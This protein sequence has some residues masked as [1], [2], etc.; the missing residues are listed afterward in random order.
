[1]KKIFALLVLFAL[2]SSIGYTQNA[3]GDKSPA[4][5]KEEIKNEMKRNRR[6]SRINGV[7][8]PKDIDDAIVQLKKL[9]SDKSLTKFINADEKIVAKKLHFGIGRWMIVNWN[10]YGGSRFEKVLRDLGLGHPDDMADFM[11]I[12]FHRYLNNKDLDSQVLAD[13]FRKKRLEIYKK[14]K[15]KVIG[16]IKKK[17]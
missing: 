13:E 6:K 9:S 10:F 3:D 15:R 7:Y 11:I 17:K 14:K 8:I 5:T 12:V 2:N 4:S 16:V 1:M